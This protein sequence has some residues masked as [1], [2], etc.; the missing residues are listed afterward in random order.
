MMI[1]IVKDTISIDKWIEANIEKY[2]ANNFYNALNDNS[3]YTLKDD[4][5]ETIKKIVHEKIKPTKIETIHDL[6]KLLNGNECGNELGNDLL[7]DIEGFCKERN[8]LIV[9]PYSDDNVELR[10]AIDD[11]ISAWDGTTIRFVKSGD[12][13][14]DEDDYECYHKASKN[15]FIT[16]NSHEIDEIKNKYNNWL[17]Y[18]GLVIEALW[19]PEHLP[20]YSWAYH[21]LG[22]IDYAE[23]DIFEDGEPYS[24]GMIIN[25][26]KIL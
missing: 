21:A 1:N 6:A 23:F 5:L 22:N 3:N 17:D 25:L 24:R 15:M 2:G 7:R 18:N 8:W 26:N 19:E 12:F 9:F 11:E 14:M 13:Y 4:I 10:G 20:D 16:V